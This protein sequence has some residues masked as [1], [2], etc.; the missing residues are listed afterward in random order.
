MKWKASELINLFLFHILY[1][2]KSFLGRKVRHKEG[3][4]LVRFAHIGDFILWLDAAKEFKNLYQGKK[5]TLLCYEYKNIKEIAEKTGYFDE[6]IIVNTHGAARIRSLL[7]MMKKNYELVINANPSR[8]VLSDLYVMAPRAG[9]RIAPKA[10]STCMKEKFIKKS[11]RIYNQVMECDDIETM[12]LVRNAQFISGLKQEKYVSTLPVL[13][14][15]TEFSPPVKRYFAVCPG[16]ETPLK[17]WEE[18][19]F[20]EVIRAVFQMDKTIS[21]IVLGTE[22]EAKLAKRILDMLGILSGRTLQYAGRTNLLQYIELIRNAEF[23]I[24]NDTS[25]GHIAAATNTQAY[26]VA[27]SW[28]KGR[29]YPYVDEKNDKNRKL[30]VVLHAGLPCTGCRLRNMDLRKPNCL[31]HGRMRC[32]SS[33]TAEQMIEVIRLRY[34]EFYEKGKTDELV[35]K[36]CKKDSGVFQCSE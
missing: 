1:W 25:A 18:E 3:I 24:T 20:A 35:G 34:Q 11:D 13:K 7:Y 16:G 15:M 5:I 14:K 36:N 8:T 21:C 12:E 6:I 30:P 9:K 19:K 17:Y 33:I 32:V 29:F 26:V 10:D 23:L 2:R 4:L 22:Q 28:D 27:V 31:E